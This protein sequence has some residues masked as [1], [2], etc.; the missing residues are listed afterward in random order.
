M[1]GRKP[2]RLLGVIMLRYSSV[3][4]TT[5][6]SIPGWRFHFLHHGLGIRGIVQLHIEDGGL[7]FPLPLNPAAWPW[8]KLPCGA[9]V[10]HDTGDAEVMIQDLHGIA[11]FHMPLPRNVIIHQHIVGPRK[12]RLQRTETAHPAPRNWQC[13]CHRLPPGRPRSR[14]AI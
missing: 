11:D 14:F 8:N 2:G 7:V 12:G 4:C 1:N 3:D 10:F 13:R 6:F 5:Y 9:P